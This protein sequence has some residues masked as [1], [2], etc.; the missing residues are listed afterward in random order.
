MFNSMNAFLDDEKQR[1]QII[2]M[3]GFQLVSKDQN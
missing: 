2:W 3:L 1:K